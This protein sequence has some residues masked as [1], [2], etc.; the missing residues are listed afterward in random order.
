MFP[1]Q[2]DDSESMSEIEDPEKPVEVIF[3]YPE[4]MNLEGNDQKANPDEAS[5][6][7]AQ[8]STKQISND[9]DDNCRN[10]GREND[11]YVSQDE[12]EISKFW[13]G[14]EWV[15]DYRGILKLPQFIK[16]LRRKIPFA[17]H[18]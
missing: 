3:V 5:S 16:I 17:R 15:L 9:S 1:V 8:S 14:F 7:S 10:T 18:L 13:I 2:V 4:K 11:V 6:E 12:I